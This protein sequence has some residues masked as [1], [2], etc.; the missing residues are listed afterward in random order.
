MPATDYNRVM[1]DD[2]QIRHARQRSLP[3]IGGNGQLRLASSH[4]LII[5]LGG[6][7]TPA[8]LYLANAGVGTLSICDFDRVDAT[9]LSRQ[10]LYQ[11]GDI[12]IAKTTAAAQRLRAENPQLR[13]NELGHRLAEDELA[14]AANAADIVLDCTDNFISR[15][16]IN[17]VCART[18]TPLISG[19]AIRFEG[20][21]VVFDFAR[22]V[23]CCYN[24]LYTDA[25]E[26]LEDC[27]GQGILPSVVGTIGAMMATETIKCLLGID[28][29]L[30]GKV[31]T[32]DALAGASRTIAISRR[33]DCLV[34]AGR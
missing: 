31:W 3:Q 2:S 5:G 20:Q 29:E 27:A 4:A 33:N 32:Y 19:A 9:N 22:S 23:N 21:L 26:N 34:C 25:D 17:S 12:G 10:I 16:L 1:S 30:N 7:G 24:C 28:T 15:S 8:S 14:G 13:I 6:L 11:S 18:Q